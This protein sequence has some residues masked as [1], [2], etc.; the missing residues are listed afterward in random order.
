MK[1]DFQIKEKIDGIYPLIAEIDFNVSTLE[2]IY[3]KL[4]M[5][6]LLMFDKYQ[7][8]HMQ[9][10]NLWN[11]S[12]LNLCKLFVENENYSFY[13]LINIIINQYSKVTFK[14]SISLKELEELKKKIEPFNSYIQSIKEI[15]DMKIAHKDSKNVFNNVM[16]HHL[17]ALIN[18]AQEIFNPIYS[19]LYDSEFRWE[20][21]NDTKELSMIKNL[22]KFEA[23]RR[24]I[25]V[26]ELSKSVSIPTKDLVKILD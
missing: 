26:A 6:E 8:L 3:G 17:R 12:M 9:R 21:K 11:V 13:C 14:K 18:L 16:L 7:L 25:N 22:A 1:T 19:A 2:Q 4:S 10:H 5:N 15:R 23:L 20:F 24:I